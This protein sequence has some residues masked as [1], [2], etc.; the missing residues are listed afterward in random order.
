MNL[1]RKLWDCLVQPTTAMSRTE[2]WSKLWG[3]VLNDRR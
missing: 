2:V 1:L 3:E